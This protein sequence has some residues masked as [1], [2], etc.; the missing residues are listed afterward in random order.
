MGFTKW[1]TRK[2]ITGIKARE[3]GRAYCDMQKTHPQLTPEEICRLV[4]KKYIGELESFAWCGG[5]A[6]LADGLV[7]EAQGFH[8]KT[9]DIKYME[10]CVIVEEMTKL[11][12]PKEVI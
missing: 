2:G 12:V 11:G 7:D 3:V 1:I 5:L 8:S 4:I 10:R 9:L 6:L